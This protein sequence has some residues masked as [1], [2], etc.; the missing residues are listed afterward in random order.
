MQGR[1]VRK[2]ERIPAPVQNHVHSLRGDVDGPSRQRFPRGADLHPQG[3][4]FAQP[5]SQSPGKPLGHVLHHEDGP[6]KSRR[7]AGEKG[8]KS[9]GTSRGSAR[10][11]DFHPAFPGGGQRCTG[12][13][14]S[15]P[16]AADPGLR[17]GTDCPKK[18]LLIFSAVFGHIRRLGENCHR[19]C[20]HGFEGSLHLEGIPAGADDHHGK[21]T[22]RF[23]DPPRCLEA[24]HASHVNVHGDHIGPALFQEFQGLFSAARRSPD[25]YSGIGF[26]HLAQNSAHEG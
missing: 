10:G 20:R 4:N 11:N 8:R 5:V 9:L 21:G 12:V 7:K 19:S 26:E 14:E 23:H 17:C 1:I 6:G 18:L 15:L 24:V 3:G 16:E 25:P 13:R 2:A 22:L